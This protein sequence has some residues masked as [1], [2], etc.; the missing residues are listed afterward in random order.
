MGQGTPQEKNRIARRA[1]SY[2]RLTYEQ[3]EKIRQSDGA[4]DFIK[5]LNGIFTF[6]LSAKRIVLD[7]GKLQNFLSKPW[8]TSDSGNTVLEI[9]NRLLQ[10]KILVAYLFENYF[11]W[12]TNHG[13]NQWIRRH[14]RNMLNPYRAVRE[15]IHLAEEA[16]YDIFSKFGFDKDPI[17]ASRI[18]YKGKQVYEK[19]KVIRDVGSGIT[20]VQ[21]NE[22]QQAIKAYIQYLQPERFNV[23]TFQFFLDRL[24]QLA[25]RVQK[26]GD[27]S[28]KKAYAEEYRQE[29]NKF[30]PDNPTKYPES[31]FKVAVAAMVAALNS[32]YRITEIN[33]GYFIM[34]CLFSPYPD[35]EKAFMYSEEF[36]RHFLTKGMFYYP[37]QDKPDNSFEYIGFETCV[38][39]GKFQYDNCRCL[40]M[41]IVSMLNHK[42]VWE[43]EIGT[44]RRKKWLRYGLFFGNG[45]VIPKGV[46]TVLGTNRAKPT[47]VIKGPLNLVSIN[48]GLGHQATQS[49]HDYF[50]ITLDETPWNVVYL[51]NYPDL[52]KISRSIGDD[53]SESEDDGNI[54]IGPAGSPFPVGGEA[55]KSLVTKDIRNIFFQKN[56]GYPFIKNGGIKE[57][58]YNKLEI[59]VQKALANCDVVIALPHLVHRGDTLLKLNFQDKD[60]TII[61]SCS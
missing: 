56:E 37:R 20:A 13:G 6:D 5:C 17:E 8:F 42:D 1:L 30:F 21:T 49:D 61:L 57:V 22:F 10:F 7:K 54:S 55:G 60:S 35:L 15:S 52:L 36:R 2:F 33:T 26:E 28:K 44:E 32:K 39:E 48:P 45:M 38:A 3:W 51:S 9:E 31:G 34:T 40:I 59:K 27:A 23:S 12:S 43:K 18:P 25:V 4:A 16:D 58:D 29:F 50:E 19:G 46:G 24:H 47:T 14:F 53:Q 41:K 11:D